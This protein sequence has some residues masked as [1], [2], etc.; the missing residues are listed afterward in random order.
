LS[1][2]P[3]PVEGAECDPDN[4]PELTQ[5]QLDDGWA[6]QA[7]PELREVVAPSRFLNALKGDIVLDPGTGIIG[8]LLRQVVP[9]QRYSHCGIMTRNYDQITHSTTSEDRL[10]DYP[11]GSIMGEPAPSDIRHLLLQPRPSGG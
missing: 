8:G 4:L 3:Q 11:N 1:A 7:T 9:P 6:C 5:E 2:T 10:L